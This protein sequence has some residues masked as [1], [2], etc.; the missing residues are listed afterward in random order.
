[1]APQEIGYFAFTNFATR[2]AKERIQQT[3]PELN[4]ENDW[5][6][7]IHSLAYRSLQNAEILTEEQAKESDPSF[8][9]KHEM[10]EVDDE[11]SALVRAKHVVA[12]AAGVAR[13]NLISFEEYLSDAPISTTMRANK[14]LGCRITP[15]NGQF[16]SQTFQTQ[17]VHREI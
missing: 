15:A 2:V 10:M 9:F 16:M 7:T 14:W 5:F 12:D 11:A 1:M 3:F 8:T 4:L 17:K 13:D 6:R